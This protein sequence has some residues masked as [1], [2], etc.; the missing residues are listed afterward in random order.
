MQ[1]KVYQNFQIL[2]NL[3][4]ELHI[5]L[6]LNDLLSKIKK[7]VRKMIEYENMKKLFFLFLHVRID[8]S[9]LQAHELCRLLFF[10][11]ECFQFCTVEMK[12]FSRFIM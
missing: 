10:F 1:L 5:P 4:A 11:G 8:L 12:L 9:A 6:L 2:L 3:S 7:H